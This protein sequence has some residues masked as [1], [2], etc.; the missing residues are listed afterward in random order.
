[1]RASVALALLAC[2]VPGCADA[3]ACPDLEVQGTIQEVTGTDLRVRLLDGEPA[4]LHVAQSTL[5]RRDPDGCSPITMGE[6]TTGSNVAFKVDAWAESYPVQG[7]P[8]T[9]IVG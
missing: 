4:V 3:G 2:I 1:M 7:W 9:V 6:V 8:E 5:L